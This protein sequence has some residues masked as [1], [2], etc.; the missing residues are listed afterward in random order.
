MTEKEHIIKKHYF[1]P[2]I[3]VIEQDSEISLALESEPP[4]F[5][6]DNRNNLKEYYFSDHLAG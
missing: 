6:S 5:E 3:E 1:Q 4:T 2:S